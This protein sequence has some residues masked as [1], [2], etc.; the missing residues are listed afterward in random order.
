MIA[1]VFPPMRRPPQR[2]PA[3]S[4]S[5]PDTALSQGFERSTCQHE[6][7]PQRMCSAGDQRVSVH[8]RPSAKSM[9]AHR[10]PG[11]D[12]HRQTSPDNKMPCGIHD[13]RWLRRGLALY[14]RAEGFFRRPSEKPV[15]FTLVVN[16][17]TLP[18]IDAVVQTCKF[19][20]THR[21]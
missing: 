7:R 3:G 19:A 9:A 5:G 21:C 11:P 8:G 15:V 4:Q 18:D 16:L 1:M 2:P 20:R 14:R 17:P 6:G 10:W 12:K 13:G